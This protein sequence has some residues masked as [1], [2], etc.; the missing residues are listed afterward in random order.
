[1]SFAAPRPTTSDDGA[2]STAAAPVSDDAR[3]RLR[4]LARVLVPAGDDMPAA[5]EAGVADDQLDAVLA[6]RPDLADD[7]RRALSAGPASPA[8]AIEHLRT[9]DGRAFRTLVLVVLAAYYRAPEVRRRLDYP[10]PEPVSVGRSTHAT[11]VDEGLL[12]HL[13]EE[14]MS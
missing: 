8:P 6:A 2:T 12:D 7:L 11:Y 14:S 5:D 1:V 3:A 9:H 4:A 10:G 13:F